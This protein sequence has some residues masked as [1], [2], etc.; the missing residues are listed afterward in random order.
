MEKTPAR[1][2]HFANIGDIIASMPAMKT[3]YEGTKR[4]VILC[5]QI[6]VEGSYYAGAI[7]PTLDEKGVQVMCNQR[8]FDMVKPLICSQDYM[9]DAEVFNDQ[10]INVDLDDIRN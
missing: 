5:Q 4:K 6:N 10:H 8:M 2:K 7:H 9:H 1:F 3:F